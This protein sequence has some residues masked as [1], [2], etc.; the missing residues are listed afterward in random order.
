MLTGLNAQSRVGGTHKEERSTHGQ[1]IGAGKKDREK[2]NVRRERERETFCLTDDVEK[3]I[4]IKT[5]REKGE[6]EQCLKEE[7]ANLD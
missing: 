1:K 6:K 5:N 7:M 2:G 4:R 3:E